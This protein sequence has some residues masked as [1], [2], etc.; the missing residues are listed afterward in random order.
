MSEKKTTTK[1][2]EIKEEVKAKEEVKVKEEEKAFFGKPVKKGDLIKLDL[3]GKTVPTTIDKKSVVFQAS[4]LEDAKQLINFDPQ[5]AQLYTPELVLVGEKGFVLDKIAEELENGKIKYGEEVLIKM[6]PKDAFG[7]RDIKKIE[8][9]SFKKFI[10]SQ[11]EKP[12]LGMDYHD[13]KGNRHGT[14]VYADQGR[15]RVDFNHPLAGR[16][17]EYKIKA[18][19]KIEDFNEK[20]MA[21]LERSM[22]GIV[23]DQFKIDFDKK[24]SILSIEVPQFFAFQQQIGYAEFRASYELQQYMEIE[25]VNFIHSFKKPK[26]PETPDVDSV[27][28]I[29]KAEILPKDEDKPKKKATEKKTTK[30]S[31]KKSSKKTTKKSTK[32]SSTK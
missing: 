17:V 12:R 22:Q 6:E 9:M 10:K 21:F 32:K 2:E 25:T 31:T 29:E 8:K 26:A 24:E 14:V 13:E 11:N 7:D 5:K 19:D 30:K 23:A 16:P 4:N 1:S 20:V 3:M 28:K 15:I 27:E 18:V